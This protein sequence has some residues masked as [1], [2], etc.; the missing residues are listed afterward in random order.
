MFTLEDAR[1]LKLT[2]PLAVSRPPSAATIPAR[3]AVALERAGVPV[4]AGTDAPNP[5]TVH[6]ASLH[7]ELELLVAAG[8]TPTSALTAATSR[9]AD[10][11]GLKD[12]GRVAPGARADLVLVEGDPTVDIRS[13]RRI[14]EVWKAGAAVDLPAYRATVRLANDTAA[15]NAKAA[16]PAGSAAGMVSDFEGA[17][18]TANFGA[19]WIP[20]TDQFIG[21]KSTASFQIESMGAHGSKGAMKVAGVIADRPQPR[22]AGAMFSPG[23]APMTPANLGSKTAISFWARGDGKPASVLLFHQA[24]GYQPSAKSFRPTKEWTRFRFELKEFDDCDGKGVL[25]LFVGGGIETGPFWFLVDDV[26][27]E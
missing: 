21:G 7:R 10:A 12:R 6:G 20:S 2:F 11:F 19:G 16:E 25:G 1:S 22:W 14:V 17:K 26:K 4:L 23:P 18:V 5:G 9:V 3:A 8:F 27:F 15:R 13:S 24:R